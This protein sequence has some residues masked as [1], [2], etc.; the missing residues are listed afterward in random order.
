[1]A[2]TTLSFQ[3]QFMIWLGVLVTL[4]VALYVLR[5][6]LLPFL[7]GMALAY[8]L[9]PVADRL[10]KTGCSRL[11]ATSIITICAVIVCLGIVVLLFPHLNNQIIAFIA[12][13]PDIIASL[14]TLIMKWGGGTLSQLIQASGAPAQNALQDIAARAVEWG[15]GLVQYI[16]S[17][18]MA[19]IALLSLLVVTP[20]VAFYLLLDWDNMIAKIDSWLPRDHAQSVRKIV[21][22]IDDALA[23]FVR[24]QVSVCLILGIFYAATLSIAGLQFGLLVGLGAGIMS[25]IPY[26]GAALGLI[27]AGGLALYQFWPDYVMIGTILGIFVFGQIMEGSVLSPKLMGRHVCLHP[28]WIIFALFAFG[29][30]FGF[31]G[32][33]LAVPAAAAIGVLA[34]FSIQ[35]YLQS[36]LYTGQTQKINRDER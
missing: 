6:I 15:L 29:A 27:V 4:I 8:F 23:G 34:R 36:P 14:E 11:A 5:S 16:W 33:L 2:Q 25:F 22:D 12:I 19:V 7:A 18:G 32:M 28:V 13:I 1:M 9:D 17:G 21:R 35:K 24:G 3:R 10:E 31:V 20:V 30:L 26:V